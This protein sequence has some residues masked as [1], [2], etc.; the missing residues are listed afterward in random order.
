[1][2]FSIFLALLVSTLSPCDG[3]AL[4]EELYPILSNTEFEGGAQMGFSAPGECRMML[5]YNSSIG[6]YL[7]L[8]AG[9]FNYLGGSREIMDATY[10]LSRFTREKRDPPPPKPQEPE[11]FVDPVWDALDE[12][13]EA[14]MLEYEET[15]MVIT[16]PGYS[17]SY[18]S[19]LARGYKGSA[20]K[21]EIST[22]TESG[23]IRFDLDSARMK[24]EC[25]FKGGGGSYWGSADI[26]DSQYLALK[27]LMVGPGYTPAMR[28]ADEAYLLQRSTEDSRH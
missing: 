23:P 27:S 12:A 20:N 13:Q 16:S 5:R 1:M 25:E 19:G 15:T 24:V 4:I 8:R 21:G 28:K 3:Q 26:D 6:H 18:L 17:R 7:Q 11:P 10:T 9:I 2:R 22:N 14:G